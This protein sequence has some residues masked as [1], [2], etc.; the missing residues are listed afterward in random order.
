MVGVYL[1][2]EGT[3]N[4]EIGF[5]VPIESARGRHGKPSLFTL[6]LGPTGRTTF[7]VRTHSYLDEYGDYDLVVWD[8]SSGMKGRPIEIERRRFHV[9]KP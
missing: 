8:A 2:L 3:P 4:T 9:L 5:A 7:G 1:E 6:R